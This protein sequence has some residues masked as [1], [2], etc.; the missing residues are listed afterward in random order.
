MVAVDDIVVPV[1]LARDE[2]GALELKG[3]F[4]AARLGR[5]LVL[6]E[7]ELSGVVV[8]G[9]EKVDGL[10]ARRGAESKG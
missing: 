2:R 5:A 4:P 1:S 10:D 3:A 6:G 7:R 8:P 9:T